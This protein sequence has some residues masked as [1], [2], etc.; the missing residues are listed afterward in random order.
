MIR[1]MLTVGLVLFVADSAVAQ[2]P[3][4]NDKLPGE[5]WTFEAAKG[6]LS[7]KGE[8]RVFERKV[9][10][11]EKNLGTAAVKGDEATLIVRGGGLLHGRIL[12]KRDSKA[13]RGV[14]EHSD[15]S[16]WRIVVHPKEAALP[17]KDPK[18]K[19]QK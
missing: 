17:N 3:S 2:K 15:G 5:V 14:V 18:P 10:Q 12:L 4:D 9:F 16:K 6:E 1:S 11:G 13:W 8:F 7:R 19:K